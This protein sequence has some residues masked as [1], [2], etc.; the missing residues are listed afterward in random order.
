MAFWGI[1]QILLDA[2]AEPLT[3]FVAHASHVVLLGAAIY[4]VVAVVFRRL[5]FEP[6]RRVNRHLYGIATGHV[7]PLELTTSV[8][9]VADLVRGVDL[10]VERMRQASPTDD[11]VAMQ[12]AALRGTEADLRRSGLE[13]LA[14]RV[15]QHVAWLEATMATETRRSAVEAAT[16]A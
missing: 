16:P 4:L 11:E 14:D 2:D 5:V 10:M 15:A 7:A 6:I 12:L 1:G 13:P 8:S 3:V 9:E